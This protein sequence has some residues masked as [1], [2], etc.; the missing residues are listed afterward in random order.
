RYTQNEMG[1]SNLEP[2]LKTFG[3]LGSDTRKDND[4]FEIT[5]ALTPAAIASLPYFYFD[6]GTE[7]ADQHT[8]ANRELS[9]LFL[10]K[11]ISHEYRELPGNHSWVYWD[12]QVQVVLKIAA[13]KMRATG[14][15]IENRKPLSPAI[16][17]RR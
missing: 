13:E 16:R 10:E 15:S 6:C 1:G 5:K 12:Q 17:A 4:V 8:K 14:R 7:D 3:A 2:F 9:E 11:K